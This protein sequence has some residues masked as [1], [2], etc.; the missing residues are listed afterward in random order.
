MANK[1]EIVKRTF[2]AKKYKKGSEMRKRLNKDAITSEYGT[3]KFIVF[4][5][6]RRFD[7]YK[8]LKSA[9]HGVKIDKMY[10]NR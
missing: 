3:D 9:E 4:K 1:Y 2:L 5:N 7:S 10:N 8:T 6:K